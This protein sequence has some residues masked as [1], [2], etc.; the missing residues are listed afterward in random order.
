MSVTLRKIR[1]GNFEPVVRAIYAEETPAFLNQYHQSAGQGLDVCVTTTVTNIGTSR[2]FKIENQS[3][4]LVGFF[5][6]DTID[7]KQ[8][9]PSFHIRA[10]FRTPE[11]LA[12][13]WDLV[14]DTFDNDF[15]TSVSA[16][17][18]PALSHLVKNDFKVVNNLEY[19]GTNWVVLRTS[20]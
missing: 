19:N 1:V 17:N 18:F 3:G 2:F 9:M 11:Y 8:V 4:A 7:G 12:A 14:R 15:Y 13:F 10:T 5:T 16:A 6:A 20:N